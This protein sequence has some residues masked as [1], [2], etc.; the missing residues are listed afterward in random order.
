MQDGPID[1]ERLIYTFLDLVAMNSPSRREGRVAAWVMAR[2][3]DLGCAVVTDN[4]AAVLDGEANNIIARLPG[5]VAGPTVLFCAH[6][7]TVQPTEHLCVVRENSRI[8]TDGSSILGADDKAGVAAILEMLRCLHDTGAPHPPLEIAF[9]VAEEVGVMGAMVL[10][11]SLLSATLGF[12][13]DTSGPV[14]T[15]ITRAPA[16]K[17]LKITV[18]GTAAHAGMAPEQGISAITVA[19]QAIARMRQGRI[20]DETTANI[21]KIQGGQATNIVPEIVEMEGEARSRDPR[22]LDAQV[23]HMVK[24]FEDAAQDA[25]ASVQVEVSDVYPAFRVEE[26]ALPV[27]LAAA[28]LAEMDIAPDIHATGGGSDANFI[29]QHGIPCVILSAGYQHPHTTTEYL[30]EDELVN[31]TAWLLRIVNQTAQGQGD[32]A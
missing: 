18:R 21:G 10:D 25:G 32:M 29:N 11:Y 27:R 14:G 5:T 6:I 8:K 19:A 9:T 20:D 15:I 7:D 16:Q 24:V 26:D 4:A 1:R 2:L 3:Q 17:H 31:L 13:P 30:D 23:A 22:K 12:V 28:A